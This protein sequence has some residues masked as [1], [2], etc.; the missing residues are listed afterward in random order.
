MNIRLIIIAVFMIIPVLVFSQSGLP[1]NK[2]FFRAIK[3][4][5][6]T[7]KGI[8]GQ[9]YWQN[10][11]SYNI[12]V[13][14]IPDEKKLI[15][16]EKIVFENNSPDTLNHILLHIYQNLYQKGNPKDD[17]IHPDDIHSGVV[18]KHVKIKEKQI[19]ELESIVTVLKIN[20]KDAVYPSE[21]ITIEVEWCFTIPTKSNI[22]MGAKDNTSFFLGHWFPRIAVYD[23]LKG[24]DTDI[25]SGDE[26]FYYD[27]GNFEYTVKVPEGYMVWGT[28]L[29]QNANK[30]LS[31]EIYKKYLQANSSDSIISIICQSDY[32]SGKKLTLKNSWRFKADNISD[33]AFGISNHFLWDASSTEIAGNRVLVEA[34]YPVQA[35]DFIEVAY[36][37]KKSI[38]YLSNELPG[39]PYPFPAVTIFN[40]TNGRSGMEYPMI[41][42]NPSAE[43]RGR[44]VDVTMHEIAH[45]YF[46]FFV[47]T[48]ETEHA[49]MD[50]SFAAMIP[51]EY[52]MI[53][54]PTLNRLI[55]YAKQTS[56]LANTDRNIPTISNSAYVKSKISSFNFYSKPAVGL[57]VLQDMLGKEMFKKCLKTYIETW[58]RKHPAPQDFFNLVNITANRNLNWFWKSWF[59]GNGYPDLSIDKVEKKRD[60]YEIIIK[61]IGDLPVPIILKVNI[62]HGDPIIYEY[63]ADVWENTNEMVIKIEAGME[64]ESLKLGNEYIPDTNATNNYYELK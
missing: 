61:K 64:M 60:S 12:N 44:T 23:D 32:E 49:W 17:F 6:R 35:E 36:L 5:T 20:L 14:I 3:N 22:R 50:E 43:N 8:P 55:R 38:I 27:I 59:Y 24:W 41:A 51:H 26:E 58:K 46:P 2:N 21:K 53:T 45:N 52:Q 31:P 48:N 10:K 34:A 54:E 25:H 28:G 57:Y 11:A 39:I 16:F 37:A 47:L 18:I 1:I 13:E 30:V 33:V 7:L 9:D 4:Q 15:G 42:N 29:L 19:T 62:K 63:A 40:G 56:N